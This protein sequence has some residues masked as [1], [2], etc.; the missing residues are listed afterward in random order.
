MT[1]KWPQPGKV[2]VCLCVCTSAKEDQQHVHEC[3]CLW[4]LFVFFSSLG[5]TMWYDWWYVDCATLVYTKTKSMSLCDSVQRYNKVCALSV[6]W[7]FKSIKCV[8]MCVCASLHMCE[9]MCPPALQHTWPWLQSPSVLSMSSISG[10]CQT[11][12]SWRLSPGHVPRPLPGP[13]WLVEP[14]FLASSEALLSINGSPLRPR[15]HSLK[16]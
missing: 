2:C 4:G 14:L 3:V 9:C 7:A 8:R 6:L 1:G 15:L 11:N 10:P 5:V 13:P 12:G 16:R